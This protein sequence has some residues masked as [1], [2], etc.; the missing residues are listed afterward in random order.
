MAME[1]RATSAAPGGKAPAFARRL[2][3]ALAAFCAALSLQGCNSFMPVFH[4]SFIDDDGNI[5][6]VESGR[7]EKDHVTKVVSPGNGKL[8]D[9]HTREA[10]RVTLP[11]GRRFLAYQT[12]NTFPVGTMFKT[13]DDELVYVTNG[14]ACRVYAMLTDGSDHL[15]VFEGNL[16]K[17]DGAK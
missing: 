3:A 2:R 4:N 10:V 16:T 8:V 6:H 11:D 13:D 12:L 17:G 7:L 14:L 5:I 9:Y 1:P 15:L